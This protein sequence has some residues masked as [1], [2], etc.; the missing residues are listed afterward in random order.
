MKLLI[1]T[2]NL[3]VGGGVQV[4]LSFINE[5]KN[6]DS[7]N[8]YYIFLSQAVNKQIIQ[9][10][11]DERFH[12]YL[13]ETSPSKLLTRNKICTQ[14]NELE[15]NIKPDIVFSIFGPTYWTPK[16]KHVMGFAVPWL[17][18]QDSIAYNE[19]KLINRIKMRLWVKYISF[20]TKRNTNNYI[21]ETN[22]GKEKLSKV[23]NINLNNIHV[24]S[25][26]Y[27][28][29]FNDSRYLDSQHDKYIKLPKKE[30]NE[31]RLLL[32]SHNHPNKNLKIIKKVLPLLKQHNVKFVLT[33]QQDDY[34]LLFDKENKSII[35]LG[36]VSQDSCPS[37]Y[38]QCDVMF[39]PTLLE[40]FSASY[41]EAMKMKKP[42][43]TSDLSFARDVCGDAAL[44]FNP[45]DENDISNKIIQLIQNE[46]LREELIQD[47]LKKLNTFE[48]SKS[49]AEKYLEICEN[50]IKKEKNV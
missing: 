50:I 44:Y 18:S 5:L 32:V 2:S 39:L 38:T 24:V 25:N 26:T 41:P 10:E 30:D 7:E 49:R 9:D 46:K 21:I 35:N 11:F 27:S 34:N 45:L 19:L 43:L 40:V 42:I 20:Y 13:I 29:V 37:L 36:P 31:F 4:A 23:L 3:Y 1:N 15:S 16:S 8:I 48:T 17:L 28:S 47:G 6:I 12:F 14:M 22:D 33:I